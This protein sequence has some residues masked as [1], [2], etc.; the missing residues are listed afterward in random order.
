MNRNKFQTEV[1]VAEGL[2]ERWVKKK[3]EKKSER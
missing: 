1:Q 3:G 2:G